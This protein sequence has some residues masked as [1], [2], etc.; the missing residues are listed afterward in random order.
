MRAERKALNQL[1]QRECDLSP[2][3]RKFN[4]ADL[5][6]IFL[7]TYLT[8]EWQRFVPEIS[9]LKIPDGTGG[10][11]EGDRRAI[12]CLVRGLKVQS[13]LEIGTHIGASTS[14][15]IAALRATHLEYPNQPVHI[16]SVDI[17][18]AN[19]FVKKPWLESGSTYAPRELATRLG[20]DAWIDF[21]TAD[22]LEYLEADEERYDLIFL[23]GSH[24]AKIVYAEV[25]LALKRLN[26]DG[27]ILL[28]DYYP[29]LKPLWPNNSTVIV[30]PYLAI[31]RF[32]IDGE[33]FRVLP[34]HQLPWPTKGD[35][36][37]TS[38]AL[39]AG[40]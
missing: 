17:V 18:D 19:D 35:S 27:L 30:G 10:I 40:E 26:P 38:L 21:V 16:T 23:D 20:A 31:Q 24:R 37:A 29:D 14:H 25:P 28:H 32:Q 3:N 36:C 39:L 1:A 9:S 11:N 22:S 12:Y 6:G 33:Q 34:F 2:L 15:I 5:E 7:S 8:Q 4:Q 13:V